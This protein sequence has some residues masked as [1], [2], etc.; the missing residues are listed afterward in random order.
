VSVL[1]RIAFSLEIVPSE[2]PGISTRRFRW[3]LTASNGQDRLSSDAYATRRE[4]MREGEIHLER[5]RE[6]GRLTA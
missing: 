6:R 3:R 4:A 5:A 2:E 1:E